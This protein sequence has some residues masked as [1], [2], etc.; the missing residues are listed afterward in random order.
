MKS[1]LVQ[2]N[3]LFNWEEYW[4]KGCNTKIKPII[5][6]RSPPR[7]TP[8]DSPPYQPLFSSFESSSSKGT[9]RKD[10]IT[11]MGGVQNPRRP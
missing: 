6:F 2:T 11:N 8:L 4:K 5:Y 10:T 7:L 1:P 9:S 3:S